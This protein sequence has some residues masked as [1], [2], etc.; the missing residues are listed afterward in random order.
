M[1]LRDLGID[2]LRPQRLEPRQRAFF[3]GAHQFLGNDG[4]PVCA[5]YVQHFPPDVGAAKLWLTNRRPKDWRERREVEVTGT[6]DVNPTSA[7]Q[8]RRGR[9]AS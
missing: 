5:P 9:T 3:V 7:S 4:E 2:Q 6:L 8:R 1:V